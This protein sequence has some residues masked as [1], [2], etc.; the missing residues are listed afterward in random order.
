MT[1]VY[2]DPQTIHN[3]SAGGKP[4]ATWGDTVRD[5]L[6]F[7]A[8]P[9]MCKVYRTTD[10]TGLSS[11]GTWYAVSFDNED[12]DTDAMH[13]NATNPSRITVP[14]TGRYAIAACVGWDGDTTGTYRQAAI[15]HQGSTFL[16][17]VIDGPTAYTR[18]NLYVEASVSAGEYVELVAAH[19]ATSSRT[20]TVDTWSK[21]WLSARWISR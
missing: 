6:E 20:L 10:F 21:C 3:P 17:V 2:V 8:S 18:Q 1:T 4:P 16:T 12:W 19:D 7:F 15:R 11:T 5:D 14:F 9:P 13:S